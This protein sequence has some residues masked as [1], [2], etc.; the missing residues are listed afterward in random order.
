MMNNFTLIGRLSKD[1]ELQ[2][3]AN[4]TSYARCIIAVDDG[5]GDKKKTYF[6]PFVLYNETAS[7]TAKYCSKGSLI[8]IQGRIVMNNYTDKNGNKRDSLELNVSKIVFLETKKKDDPTKLK[9]D[10]TALEDNDLPF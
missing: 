9:K 8:G 2:T 1:I 10:E 5:F 6:I 7:N 3:A 4:G